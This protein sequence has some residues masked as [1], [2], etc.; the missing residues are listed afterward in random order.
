MIRQSAA[1]LEMWIPGFLIAMEEWV[2]KEILQGPWRD[3]LDSKRLITDISGSGNNC[4]MGHKVFGN[5]YQEQILEKLSKSA[6]LF[7]GL[8][9]FL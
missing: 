3:V 2:V 4:A 6:E 9:C 1:S 8:Q 5:L 7:D